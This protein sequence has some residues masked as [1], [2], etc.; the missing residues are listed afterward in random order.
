METIVAGG[1]WYYDV[2]I[3][4]EG[5]YK[6]YVA[7]WDTSHNLY[8]FDFSGNNTIIVDGTPPTVGSFYSETSIYKLSDSVAV[9]WI[10]DVKDDLSGIKQVYVCEWKS[11]TGESGFTVVQEFSAS[12]DGTTDNYCIYAP[13]SGEGT[14][15]FQG[16]VEDNAGNRCDMNMTI[17]EYRVQVDGTPPTVGSVSS[18]KLY[19]QNPSEKSVRVWYWNVTD[20]LSGVRDVDVWLSK[21]VTFL[22]SV[23]GVHD[24][25]VSVGTFKAQRDGATNN[26]YFDAPL[27]GEGV[28]RFQGTVHDFCDNLY[29][30]KYSEYRVYVDATP[31]NVEAKSVLY[32]NTVTIGISDILVGIHYWAVT[33]EKTPPATLGTTETMTG[34]QLNYWYKTVKGMVNGYNM[35]RNDIQVSFQNLPVGTYYAWGRDGVGN[36]NCYE[37]KVVSN[38][39]VMQWTVPA[40]ADASK[41]GTTIQLPMEANSKNFVVVDWGDGTSDNYGASTSF[42]S[43]TYTNTGTVTYTIKVGGT[44]YAF[45]YSQAMVPTASNEYKNYY[46]FTQY[47]TKLVEWGELGV[48]GKYIATGDGGN[49][50]AYGFSCCTKLAGAI[51]LPSANSFANAVSMEGLFRNC[52][53]LTGSIPATL[54]QTASN[55]LS[56]ADTFSSCRK[57]TGLVPKELFAKNTKIKDM[58]QTFYDCQG[59]V[60]GEINVNTD[61]ITNM[62]QMFANCVALESLVWD[63]NVKKLD[64]QDM[65]QGDSQLTAVILLYA[66]AN[67]NAIGGIHTSISQLTKQGKLYV[68][69]SDAEKL[70]EAAWSA[71]VAADKIQPIVEPIPPNPATVKLEATY[72]DPGY[73]VAGYRFDTQKE[74]YTQYGFSVQ[75]KGNPVDTKTLGKKYIDYELYK[76]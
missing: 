59:L 38:P 20:N 18:D 19:I 57:L 10:R 7:V 48:E 42:P 21:K 5:T 44:L 24:S 36:E 11:T 9:I 34:N 70:Y 75:I 31:P 15:R 8:W 2:P 62:N 67:R 27:S 40:K 47:L 1:T 13:L 51:P 28:Y 66:P 69:D 17:G 22:D 49:R 26:W 55:V 60:G 12:R 64:G 63:S 23:D 50:G 65:F 71:T 3:T 72:T 35:Y 68:V 58:K 43:H 16:W 6:V 45:G 33:T 32:P 14:Y 39:I 41:T 54:F 4:G 37:F 61:T 76:E 46:S 53:S 30:L 29:D 52:S 56:F 74:K 73:T 25:F